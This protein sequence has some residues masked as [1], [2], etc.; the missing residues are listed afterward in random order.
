MFGPVLGRV[1][2]V[3]GGSDRQRVGLSL[4]VQSF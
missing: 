1:S 2:G 3:D 4:I